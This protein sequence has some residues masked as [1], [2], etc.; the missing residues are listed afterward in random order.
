MA[1]AQFESSAVHSQVVSREEIA[2]R[3]EDPSL[4]LI[5]VLPKETFALGHIP[6][7]INLPV[8]EI[9]SRAPDLL[10]HRSGEITVY[11]AGP[12]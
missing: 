1:K 3:L 8:G 12:T 9:E 5:N 6:Q 4:V 2:A 7:S 10:P 11:C